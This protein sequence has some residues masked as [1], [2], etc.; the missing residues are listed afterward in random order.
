MLRLITVHHGNG[1]YKLELHGTLGGEWVPVLEKQWRALARNG[2]SAGVTV[3]LSNV[4]FI[5]A[6][7]ERLLGRMADAGVHF[8]VSGCMNR[9]VVEKLQ[10]GTT[11]TGERS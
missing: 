11:R 4:D 9:Y 6:P 5:D 7:G 2:A 8:E 3:V 10:A 1:C